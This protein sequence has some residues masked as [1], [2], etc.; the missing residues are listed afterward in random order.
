MNRHAE[1]THNQVLAVISLGMLLRIIWALFVPVE[2]I[3]DSAAYDA[4]ARTLATHGVYGWT[5]AEPG[6]FWAVGTSA[7]V[8]A[9][10]R[11]LGD[12]YTGVVVLNL[13]A[14]LLTMVLVFRLGEIWFGRLPAFLATACIAIWPNLIAFTTILSSELYFIALT[15]LGLWYWERRDGAPWMNVLLCGVAWGLACYVRPVILLLPFALILAALPRGTASTARTTLRAIAAMALILV[16][17]SPWTYRNLQLFGEPVL[18]ST[19]FGPNLWMGNNPDTDGGYMHPPKWAQDMTEIE[20]AHALG[21]AAKE[22]IRSDIPGFVVRT[23]RKAAML[24]A[25][26]TI[27]VSWNQAAIERGLGKAAVVGMKV[28]STGF[29]LLMLGAAIGGIIVMARRNIIEALLH[30]TVIAWAYFA[31]IPAVIVADQRYHMPA[32]PFIALLTGAFCA[33]LIKLFLNKPAESIS[34]GAT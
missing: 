9:T 11:I 23:M 26:E 4:F 33:F 27:G 29:W 18:V 24:H 14:S 1:I 28:V 20:R 8:A 31:A 25:S 13:L 34:H 17:V 30:P 22:Y 19:N 5:A 16:V 21:D 2:P 7:I 12:S 10:Y 15:L 6:A 3:S 32:T